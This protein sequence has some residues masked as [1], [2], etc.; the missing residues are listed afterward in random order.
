MIKNQ[1]YYSLVDNLK[2]VIDD[3]QRREEDA[4]MEKIRG[5]W[6]K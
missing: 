3:D 2:V 1:N 6:D 5:R 4:E